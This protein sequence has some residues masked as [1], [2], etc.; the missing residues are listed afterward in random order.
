[1]PSAI[2][3]IWLLLKRKIKEDVNRTYQELTFFQDKE[4]IKI[5][6]DILFVWCKTQSWYFVQGGMNELL[7]SIGYAYFMEAVPAN[8]EAS[9]EY[10][11]AKATQN[12][13]T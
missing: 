1:M 8:F 7:A 2:I 9:Y 11:S 12:K 13:S 6:S 10:L 4:I 5:L 3:V